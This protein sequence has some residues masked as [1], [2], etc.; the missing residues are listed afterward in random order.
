MVRSVDIRTWSILG[1]RGTFGTYLYN[2]SKENEDIVA[3][4]ADLAITSGLKKFFD[5]NPDRSYN[6]GIAENN[7]I[8]IAAGM[9]DEGKV[10]FATTFSNFAALRSCEHIRHFMGYMNCNVKLVGIGAGF[11]MELFGNT[12]YA[13]EDMAVVRSIPN[14]VLLSP[15]DGLELTKCVKAAYEHEGPVYIRLTGVMN[16]PV[17]YKEDYDFEIGKAVVIRDGSDV[18]LY[19][20]GSMVSVTLKAA[21]ILEEKGISCRVVDVHTVK[22]IDKECILANKDCKLYVSVEE[23]RI[24]GGLG[25]AIAD[26][27]AETGEK[28]PA[29]LKLGCNE[30]FKRAGTYPYM[31]EQYRLTPELIAEDVMQ[32]LEK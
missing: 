31:L 30:E 6:I 27:M 17:V 8:G 19:A 18:T 29:L 5:N 1:M 15:A 4:T 16:H 23:H 20:T 21:D 24:N 32:K 10:P 22:P 2:L 3:L 14:V 7:M 25:S 12:H 26:V 13:I 28:M 9:A 11:A